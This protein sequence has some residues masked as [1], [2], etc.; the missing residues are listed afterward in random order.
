MN[1]TCPSRKI[2]LH[3][4]VEGILSEAWAV[5]FALGWLHAWLYNYSQHNG[6]T[7]RAAC[8]DAQTAAKE[9]QHWVSNFKTTCDSL[10]G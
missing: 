10:C 4:L 3:R 8:K 6:V 1:R 2:A 9:T 5:Y 7:Q